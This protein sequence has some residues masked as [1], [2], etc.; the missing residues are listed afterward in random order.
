MD[1][2]EVLAVT[3]PLPTMLSVVGSIPLLTNILS[4]PQILFC[5]E[6]FFVSVTYILVK[7]PATQALS[8]LLEVSILKSLLGYLLMN[9]IIKIPSYKIPMLAEFFRV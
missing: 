8:D 1:G 3:L 6:L 7:F 5:V 9:D 4:D 2:G